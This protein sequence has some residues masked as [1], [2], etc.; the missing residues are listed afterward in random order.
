MN[1]R[2][3]H[4]AR[5]GERGRGGDARSSHSSPAR[6]A[7]RGIDARCS[8]CFIRHFSRRDEQCSRGDQAGP[9]PG[10]PGNRN[11]H[12]CCKVSAVAIISRD[13]SAGESSKPGWAEAGYRAEG[14]RRALPP[15]DLGVMTWA[16]ALRGAGRSFC[17]GARGA[18]RWSAPLSAPAN[19]VHRDSIQ[20]IRL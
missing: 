12:C 8:S 9:R 17:P 5:R 15:D 14:L 16:G 20:G 3:V 1:D 2:P 10:H 18:G 7:G 11:M 19:S 13:S 4:R 6:T